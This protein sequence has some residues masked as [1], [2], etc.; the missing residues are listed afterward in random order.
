LSLL[1]APDLQSFYKKGI[2]F[3][4]SQPMLLPIHEDIPQPRQ[5]NAVVE[6]LRNGGVIIY[7]TDTIYGLG[8][9]IRQPKAIE[10]VCRIKNL[11]PSKAKLSFICNDLKDLS[12]YAKQLPNNI[13]RLLKEHLPGPYT[14]VLPASKKV[15]KILKTKKDTIGL[16]VPDN[17]IARAI[18][19]GIG[20]PILSTSLP[21]ETVEEFADPEMI[22]RNFEHMVDI[23][24]DGGIGGIVPSTV[25]DCTGIEPVVLREGLG[26]WVS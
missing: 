2:K 15:P 26:K 24:V 11:N 23:V 17:N 19:R 13:F 1:L 25:I 16:R 18:V 6:V 10:R 7:P 21:G 20:N 14:F 8:C 3:P 9:D 12:E 5:V 22:Y 4:E